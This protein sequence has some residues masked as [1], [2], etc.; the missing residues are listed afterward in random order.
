MHSDIEKVLLNTAR[1]PPLD[2]ELQLVKLF[3]SNITFDKSIESE[4]YT[5]PTPPA[6]LFKKKQ[7]PI[8]ISPFF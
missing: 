1:T 8:N 7:S 3:F 5:P 4:K 6:E 2:F